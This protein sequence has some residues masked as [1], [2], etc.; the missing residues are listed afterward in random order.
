MH[1]FR[2]AISLGREVFA[3][4]AAL[5]RKTPAK[6]SPRHARPPTRN[7]PRRLSR[8]GSSADSFWLTTHILRPFHLRDS[9]NQGLGPPKI[10]LRRKSLR[11]N[12]SC[13]YLGI[14]Q[15]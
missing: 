2:R 8:L 11:Y 10:P 3:P 6:C 13:D 9:T 1:D 7:R 4:P 5:A 14:P 15:E 12:S